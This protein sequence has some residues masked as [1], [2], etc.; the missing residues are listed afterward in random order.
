[1][2]AFVY[3]VIALFE[4][5]EFA[6]FQPFHHLNQIIGRDGAR[7]FSRSAFLNRGYLISY[8]LNEFGPVNFS[9]SVYVDFFE[10]FDGSVH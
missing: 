6:E 2:L 4:L 3:E 8:I 10:K 5:V 7:P 1:M 9:V